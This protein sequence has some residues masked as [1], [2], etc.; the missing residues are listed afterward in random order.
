MKLSLYLL[1]VYI[2]VW[3]RDQQLHVAYWRPGEGY[4]GDYEDD[5]AEMDLALGYDHVVE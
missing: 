4:D 3:F 1:W 5:I 2:W